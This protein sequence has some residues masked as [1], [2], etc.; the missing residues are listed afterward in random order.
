MA[1]EDVVEIGGK[2]YLPSARAAKLVGYTK[3]YVGQ[4]ARAG[5]LD[6]KLVGRGWYITEDSIRAHKLSVHYELTKPKKRNDPPHITLDENLN[7]INK[8]IKNID[9]FS[10]DDV[11]VQNL[12]SG[13]A[14]DSSATENDSQDD[15]VTRYSAPS[16]NKSISYSSEVPAQTLRH[17]VTHAKNELLRARVQFEQMTPYGYEGL[18]HGEGSHTVHLAHRKPLQSEMKGSSR[19]DSGMSA[20]L[21]GEREDDSFLLRKQSSQNAPRVRSSASAMVSDG[22]LLKNTPQRKSTPKRALEESREFE[23]HPRAYA[24][25]SRKGIGIL[26]IVSFLLIGFLVYLLI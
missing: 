1:Q 4:L 25:A 17:N 14:S 24:G 6:A 8:T 19:L 5:K 3:D 26:L 15:L 9:S 2:Q 21:R 10:T 23:M 13:A 20:G 22:I 11:Q 16:F 7:S 12:V 18:D